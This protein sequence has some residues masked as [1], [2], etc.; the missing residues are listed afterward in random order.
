MGTEKRHREHNDLHCEIPVTYVVAAL[1][2]VVE[3]P[4]LSG[5]VNLTIPTE[6][7]NGKQFRLRGKGVKALRGGQV[8]DLLCRVIVETP[9]NLTEEQKN[10]LREFDELLKNDNKNHS[11]KSHS[12]FNAVKN[13]FQG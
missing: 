11:P 4:T 3:V 10:K 8:G 9:V 1:G 7:Q 2:G 13:F 6:T 5:S 12:W